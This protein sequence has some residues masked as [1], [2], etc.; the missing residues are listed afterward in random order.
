MSIEYMIVRF[1]YAKSPRKVIIKYINTW[2]VFI[3]Q[4]NKLN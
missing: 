2:R 1:M 3:I 4:I